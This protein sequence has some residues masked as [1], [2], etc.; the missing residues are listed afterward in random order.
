MISISS[1][2]KTQNF[3]TDNVDKYFL[4]TFKTCEQSEAEEILWNYIKH[5]YWIIFELL[6]VQGNKLGDNLQWRLKRQPLA[7][8]L[9]V[10]WSALWDSSVL[11]VTLQIKLLKI[12]LCLGG[13]WFLH[14]PLVSTCASIDI[15]WSFLYESNTLKTFNQKWWILL[16]YNKGSKGH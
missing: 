13:S 11:E 8:V 12:K 4:C 15:P 14:Y 5:K 2:N 16:P 1:K 7:T 3:D 6:T 9:A 10:E